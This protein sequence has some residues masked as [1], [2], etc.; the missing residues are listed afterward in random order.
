MKLELPDV[1]DI[2]DI[3]INRL[4]K[5]REEKILEEIIKPKDN[6]IQ[7]LYQDNM[8]LHRQLTKQSQVLEE[9]EK[10]QKERNRIIVDNESLHNEVDKIKSEYKQKELEKQVKH[11]EKEKEWDLEL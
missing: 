7:N 2:A 9:V 8:D 11:E 10:Y 1:P 4:S 6:I 5:K 3:N